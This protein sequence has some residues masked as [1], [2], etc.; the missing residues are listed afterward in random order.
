MEG[1]NWQLVS[2]DDS[3]WASVQIRRGESRAALFE[4]EVGGRNYEMRLLKRERQM[5][6]RISGREV[7]RSTGRHYNQQANTA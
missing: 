3:V 5:I 2:P 1:R 7:L 4:V 6:E